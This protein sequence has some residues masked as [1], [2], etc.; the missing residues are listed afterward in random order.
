[1]KI[2]PHERWRDGVVQKILKVAGEVADDPDLA[3]YYDLFFKYLPFHFKLDEDEDLQAWEEEEYGDEESW[4][5]LDDE[6]EETVE[7]PS[8]ALQ[9]VYF[10]SLHLCT[11]S[12][13]YTASSALDKDR[14]VSR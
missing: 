12:D 9:K 2:L 5:P 14:F 11:I 6:D 8:T 1:M 13:L 4:E 7:V 10:V 3:E